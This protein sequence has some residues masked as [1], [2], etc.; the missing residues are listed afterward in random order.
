[1]DT[2]YKVINK[3]EYNKEC[4]K[5]MDQ[6]RNLQKMCLICCLC[7]TTPHQRNTAYPNLSSPSR[8]CACP[9]PKQAQRPLRSHNILSQRKS[10][11]FLS[12]LTYFIQIWAKFIKFF[13]KVVKPVI[14]LLILLQLLGGSNIYNL[15]FSTNY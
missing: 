13:I 5:A 1:L 7:T 8:H 2:S 15:F 9:N 10:M 4:M 6:R 14:I 12:I 11:T 3:H